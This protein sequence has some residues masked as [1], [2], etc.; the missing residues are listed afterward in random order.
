MADESSPR[1]VLEDFLTLFNDRKI[2]TL[3]Q[4]T[5]APWL[6]IVDG[7][8]NIFDAFSD[9]IDFDGL[10]D[11]GWSYTR[12]G[13]TEVLHSDASTVFLKTIVERF[14]ADDQLIFSGEFVVL[15]ARKNDNWGV[16]GWISGGNKILLLGK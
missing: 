5:S 15:L 13:S 14:D 9:M 1:L 11:T 10:A 4:A 3:D 12:I 16:A 8:T 6:T 7:K 2:T